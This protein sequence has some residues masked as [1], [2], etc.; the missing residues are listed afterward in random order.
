MQ[1][2]RSLA[3]R[4]ALVAVAGL[5]FSSGTVLVAPTARPA[6]ADEVPRF[7]IA[8]FGFEQGWRREPRV[9]GRLSSSD[10]HPRF[11]ADVTGDGRGDIVGMGTAG[12][13]VAVAQPD[14]SFGETTFRQ[15]AFGAAQ[16]WNQLDFRFVTDITGDK[17]ADLVGVGRDGVWTAVAAGDGSFA[18]AQ[19]RIADPFS[20]DSS[21]GT[22]GFFAA[23]FNNDQRSDLVAIAH[24]RITVALAAGDGSFGAPFV[25]STGFNQNTMADPHV[26]DLTNDGRADI[27]VLNNNIGGLGVARGQA[28]LTFGA[29]VDA[30]G[31]VLEGH[32]GFV[33]DAIGDVTGDGR[34][35][36]IH[37]RTGTASGPPGTYLAINR[38]D[39]TFHPAPRTNGTD[40]SWRVDRHSAT[41]ADVTG[42][43]RADLIMFG[44]A[45]VWVAISQGNGFGPSQFVLADFGF[46]Q[47]W[48]LDRH[49]RVAADINEG[50][51]NPKADLIGFGDAG[52]YVAF[53]TGDGGFN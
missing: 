29:F 18:P 52:V 48:Q 15:A 43:R 51:A 12:V 47:D 14:G 39:G 22:F 20:S 25:A 31:R 34:P 53:A 24:Q 17:K 40:Q 19:F 28:N 11:V 4:T 21:T 23:D 45:G 26:T 6:A 30:D 13:W 37:I 42:D 10:F 27:L 3:V 35:D 8:N 32:P 49:V 41:L 50:G 9:P 16:G 5:V 38:G 7:A 46:S 44:D 1:I 2:F 36:L 33:P